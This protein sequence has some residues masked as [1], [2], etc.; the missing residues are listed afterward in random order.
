MKIL[1]VYANPNPQSLNGELKKIAIHTLQTQHQ[2]VL[3][4]LYAQ[5]FNPVASWQDFTLPASELANS[6]LAAQ[7]TAYRAQQ[8][9]ADIH[10]E[11]NKMHTADHLILQF[12]LWWFAVP[13]ILKGWLDKI[14]VKGF[15]YDTGK[16]FKEG[17]LRG[18]S[19]SLILTTQSPESAYQTN[20]AH[21]AT[22]EEFL[23]PLLHTLRFTGMEILTPYVIYQAYD[24]DQIRYAQTIEKFNTYLQSFPTA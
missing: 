12:P 13:A 8:M 19:A 14:L 22:I 23:R 17:L 4:D 5:N 16:I 3:S 10:T 24:M 2:V 9:A 7:Q 18:K 1:Y 20:G 21:G 15:A 11:I 6:Y